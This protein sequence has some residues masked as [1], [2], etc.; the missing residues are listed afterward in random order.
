MILKKIH[1]CWF[2]GNPLPPLAE[3]CINSWKK[4][5]PDYEIIEWNESNFDIA[6]CPVYVRQAYEQKKWAFVTD[7][8]RL[9]VVYDHGGIYMD[10]DV[11]LKKSLDS[12]LCHNAYF[13]FEDGEH[14]NTGLGFG[15][16][17]G[18]PLL[19]ELMDDY[20]DILFINEDGTI[21]TLPC[22]VIN[23][24]VFLRHGLVQDDSKQIL[25][26]DILVLPS[27]Y[28][29]PLS[30]NTYRYRHSFK[31]ISCHWF[32]ASWKSEKDREKHRQ[33]VAYNNRD[34]IIHLPNRILRRLFGDSNYEKLKSIL[35][36]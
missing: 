27:I 8:V 12:Q 13:G 23:T 21:N 2:G 30:Y 3:K 17:S 35:K 22:P 11:E 28:L 32:D 26:G 36:R 7:Y 19:E 18:L 15:A 34:R 1:Y 31:T 20:R 6:D 29:C 5:C 4:R 24:A 33:S 10:T 16:V 25:D 14:I 9:R